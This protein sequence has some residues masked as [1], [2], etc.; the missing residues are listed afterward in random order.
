M[1]MKHIREIAHDDNPRCVFV[2]EACFNLKCDML[3]AF[4]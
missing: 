4:T 2:V 3:T 1:K